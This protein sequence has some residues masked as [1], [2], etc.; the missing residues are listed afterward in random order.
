MSILAAQLYSP[1]L[2]A[3][4]LV[5]AVVADIFLTAVVYASNPRS[6]TNKIFSL[7]TIFTMLWLVTTYVVRLPELLAHSLVLHRFG[8]FL[9]LL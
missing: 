7:L 6:A 1:S 3:I 8:I 4:M 9:P 2:D 5:I